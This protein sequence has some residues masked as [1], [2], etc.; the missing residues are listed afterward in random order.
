MP[1]PVE[2]DV[3]VGAIVEPVSPTAT[4]MMISCCEV[5]RSE[6]CSSLG[7]ALRPVSGR[8]N[9]APLASDYVELPGVQPPSPF[10]PLCRMR[11]D[12]PESTR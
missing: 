10:H 9:R 8:R 5:P 12:T 7:S 1:V 4:A 6:T 2:I 11:Y 3:E